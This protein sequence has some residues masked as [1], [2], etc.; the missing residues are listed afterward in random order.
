MLAV[1]V[2]VSRLTRVTSRV[3]VIGYHAY[4]MLTS[5]EYRD[6]VRTLRQTIPFDTGDAILFVRET[7][8]SKVNKD[9]AER[10][11]H[12]ILASIS[13]EEAKQFYEN[14]LAQ[15]TSSEGTKRCHRKGFTRPAVKEPTV[16]YSLV[17]LF[18]SAQEGDLRL[19]K[20]AVSEKQHDINS[21]D[22]FGWTLL[23]VAAHAGHTH[24]V[25]Y[26][27]SEGAEWENRRDKRGNNAADLASKGGHPLVANRILRY[28]EDVQ[29][30]SR[31]EAEAPWFLTAAQNMRFCEICKLHV[32]AGRHSTSV[33]HQF[34]CQHQTNITSYGIPE[35]NRGFQLLLKRGW[36]RDKG[37][38]AENQGLK[39]PIRTVLKHDRL[40]LG[41]SGSAKPRVTH[42]QPYDVDAVRPHYQ[43]TGNPGGSPK[44]G[45]ST[46]K[47]QDTREWEIRMRRYM[48]SDD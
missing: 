20:K 4:V 33:A 7:G 9:G 39:Y 37:L 23:M 12:P 30:S 2:E 40:G 15:S 32:S 22:E 36:D 6:T 45:S 19:I 13:G 34:S 29:S 3:N 43:R 42:F 44:G 16:K 18:R 25:E 21:V 11:K 38:G 31:Q 10:D 47:R 14:V 17:E 46:G 1:G 35:T 26:L 8:T 5:K 27:L 48:N 28:A 41:L 24:V